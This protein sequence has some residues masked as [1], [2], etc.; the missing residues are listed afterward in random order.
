[1]ILIVGFRRGGLVQSPKL[2]DGPSARAMTVGLVATLKKF[3]KLAHDPQLKAMYEA[4]W[5]SVDQEEYPRGSKGPAVCRPSQ[6]RRD[7]RVVERKDQS[8]EGWGGVEQ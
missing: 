1:M 6:A 5:T 2:T 7:K 3:A 4:S 8:I